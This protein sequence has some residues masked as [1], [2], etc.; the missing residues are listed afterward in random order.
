MTAH[1]RMASQDLKR[2][3]VFFGRFGSSKGNQIISIGDK[4]RSKAFSV[5]ADLLASPVE[6]ARDVLAP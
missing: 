3:R 5:A 2:H 1:G 4:K 6:L